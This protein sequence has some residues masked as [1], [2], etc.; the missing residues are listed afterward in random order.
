MDII[1]KRLITLVNAIEDIDIATL[2]SVATKIGT[3]AYRNGII[4]CFGN[5]GSA[6]TA[7]HFKNDLEKYA[8]LNAD[9]KLKVN[10][11]NDNIPII[12]A[13]ANDIAYEDIFKFQIYNRLNPEDIIIAISTSGNSQNVIKAVSYAREQGNTIIGMTGG[14][15]GQLKKLSNISLHTNIELA[16]N[17]ED[18]HSIM[19]HTIASTLYEILT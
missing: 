6:A 18:I 5:G 13:V 8:C 9:T 15:G 2:Y 10:C 16:T 3:A 17:I 7:S 14:N 12:T 1:A 11:L 19:C 4:Y